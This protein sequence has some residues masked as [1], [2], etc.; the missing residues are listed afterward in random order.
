M[1]ELNDMNTSEAP[2]CLICGSELVYFTEER[3][4]TCEIC[5][6][7]F[8][9]NACC[10]NGHFVCDECHGEKALESI[11]SV[12]MTE[13]SKNPLTIARRLMNRPDV[14]MHGPEHHVLI[15]ASLLTA[16]CNA[17]GETS[18][19]LSEK[20]D[21]ES[22]VLETA[23]KEMLSRG[24]SVP[25][26]ACG[27]WGA[28]GSALSAGIFMSIITK[29]TPLSGESWG[30][31]MLLTS[32][33]LSEIGKIGGPRCCKRGTFI[34]IRETTAFTKEHLGVS[35]ELPDKIKCSFYKNNN[36]CLAGSCP[37]FP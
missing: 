16:Y 32:R 37:F 22:I 25:G 26:G 31:C 15:G 23:L 1:T 20:K 4:M 14:Y 8:K 11:I 24:K 17:A 27:F 12:C 5:G 6:R 33:I 28:C 10:K 36:E 7:Q 29:T 34:S 35:M 13:S 2:S 30:R 9:S 19:R 21:N 3:E 18:G